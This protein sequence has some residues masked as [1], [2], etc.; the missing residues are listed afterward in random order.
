VAIFPIVRE[1]EKSFLD[2]CLR[3]P[4]YLNSYVQKYAWYRD[5]GLLP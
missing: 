4:A 3:D 2:R 1:E 5:H